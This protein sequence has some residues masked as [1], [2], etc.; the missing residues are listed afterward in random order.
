[1]NF[2]VPGG[3]HFK[4]NGWNTSSDAGGDGECLLPKPEDLTS[5][6]NTHVKDRHCDVRTRGGLCR[7]RASPW[8]WLSSQ[9]LSTWARF[10]EVRELASKW[11]WKAII[12]EDTTHYPWASPCT[13]KACVLV[14]T[15]MWHTRTYTHSFTTQ[16]KSKSSDFY[17][18]RFI[19]NP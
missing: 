18:L 16:I 11:R 5:N 19:N 17:K 14:F 8:N 2:K 3:T 12:K 1:M 7:I 9:V 15:H 13:C 10:S 4:T 6:P